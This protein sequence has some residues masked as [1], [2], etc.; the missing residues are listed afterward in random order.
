MRHRMSNS[1]A[2]PGTIIHSFSPDSVR[3]P[4]FLSY[5]TWVH[6]SI[7]WLPNFYFTVV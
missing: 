7:S 1:V 2:H 5:R 6:S 3:L 4:S